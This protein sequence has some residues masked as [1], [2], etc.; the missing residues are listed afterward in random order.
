MRQEFTGMLPAAVNKFEEL[1]TQV[2]E[3]HPQIVQG[4]NS[5]AGQDSYFYWG[6]ACTIQC[7]DMV[8]LKAEAE[9]LNITWLSDNGDIAYTNCLDVNDFKTYRVNGNLELTPEQEG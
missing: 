7:D 1:L 9:S 4:Y 6:C 3:L 2:T 8:Q 5:S